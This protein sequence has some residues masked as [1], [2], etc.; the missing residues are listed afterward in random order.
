MAHLFMS[1]VVVSGTK[2]GESYARYETFRE[3]DMAGQF[4]SEVLAIRALRA[5]FPTVGPYVLAK[6]ITNR[7]FAAAEDNTT[8][9]GVGSRTRLSTLSVI[10]RYDAS[11]KTTSKAA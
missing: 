10:R 1:V 4:K 8:A 3:T 5:K 2:C 9:N 6:Q 11:I 7:S